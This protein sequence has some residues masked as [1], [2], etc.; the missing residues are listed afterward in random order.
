L[1]QNP[2]TPPETDV[3][4]PDDGPPRPV[5]GVILAFVFD[6]VGTII[7]VSIIS[8]IYTVILANQGLSE[9]EIEQILLSEDLSSMYGVI[10]TLVG[11]GFSY[12]SGQICIRVSRGKTLSY[13]YVLAGINVI[14]GLMVAFSTTNVGVM[15]ALTALSV[16]AVLLGAQH[17][18][19]KNVGAA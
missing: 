3:R 16:G 9:S 8:I 14:F 15:L 7:A 5:R 17:A 1:S 19:K 12:Y 6:L 2:Y 18:L 10:T 4:V 13:A 11:L